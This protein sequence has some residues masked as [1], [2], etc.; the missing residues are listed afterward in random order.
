[1]QIEEEVGA[2]MAV[3]HRMEKAA[4]AMTTASYPTEDVRVTVTT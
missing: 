1:M 2:L 4:A 3:C